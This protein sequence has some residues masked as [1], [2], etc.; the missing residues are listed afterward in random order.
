MRKAGIQDGK[1]VLYDPDNVLAMPVPFD[2]ADPYG[3]L[4]EGEKNM[5]AYESLIFHLSK[6]EDRRKEKGK[7]YALIDVLIL[8]VFGILRGHTDFVNMVYDLQFEEGYFTKLLNLKHGIPSHDVFSAVFRMIDKEHF[9]RVFIDWMYSI[10]RIKGKHVAIDGKA[11]RAACEKAHSGSVPYILNV[12]LADEGI[13]MGQMMIDKKSNEITGIPQILGCIDLDGATVTIDAI[14]CQ[15]EICNMIIRKGADFILPAKENQ[16]TLHHAIEEYLSDAYQRKQVEEKLSR[17]Y[18]KLPSECD[19]IRIFTEEE[20]KND[21]GRSEKRVYIVSDNTGCIDKE[22]WPHVKMIGM[23]IRTRTTI[24]YDRDGNEVSE[25]TTETNTWIV[26]RIM[27]VKE[28]AGYTR[29]HWKIE[30]SLHYVLD[31]SFREDLSTAREGNAL[32]NLAQMRKICFNFTNLCDEVKNLPKK[33]AFTYFRHHPEAVID[34]IF[35]K[36]P[37]II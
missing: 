30:N 24:K 8:T 5:Y 17:K 21:H 13:V 37:E 1:L 31:M 2:P 33:R 20:P 19:D 23:T 16:K 25:T 29:G 22:L 27:K 32:E 12:F 35:N 14:G 11:V 4:P 3:S 34:L 36:I 9:M 28:F 7:K 15:R 26:S 6:I 10:A 18:A